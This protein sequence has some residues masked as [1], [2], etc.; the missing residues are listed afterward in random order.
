M[1]TEVVDKAKMEDEQ[2]SDSKVS[3]I[4]SIEL[5]AP[6]GWSKKIIFIAPS[7]EEIKNKRQLDQYLKSHPGGP[8]SSEFDWGTGDTPRRSARLST[9]SKATE[10]PDSGSSRKKQR[11]STPKKEEDKDEEKEETDGG[12][13]AEDAPADKTE[14]DKTEDEKD[15][16][17]EDV[18][19][20]RN[21]AEDEK[22]GE[23]DV[24]KTSAVNA[25]EES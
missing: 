14:D 21:S 22:A 13:S 18:E 3:E 19:E 10:S 5:P 9:K 4:V 25:E 6:K 1:A 17:M 16:E 2:P 11:K 7:G 24:A 8:P 20:A 23:D 12:E 15:V